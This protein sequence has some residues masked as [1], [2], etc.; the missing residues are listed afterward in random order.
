MKSNEEIKKVVKEKYSQIVNKSSSCCSGCGCSDGQLP[1]DIM[2][3]SYKNVEGYIKDADLSLG[4]GIPTEFANIK[5]GDTVLDLGSGAGNDVFV[6]RNIVGDE[7]FV[8]GVDMTQ[9]MIVKAEKNKAKT[10]YQ[11]VEFRLGEIENLPIEEN[12]VDVVI[13]NCVLNLVPDKEKA[14]KEIYRVLKSGKHF[15]VSD[16]VVI[17]ELPEKIKNSLELYAGCVAGASQKEEYL[18]IIEKTGFKKIEIKKEK[19]I[20]VDEKL[21]KLFL[22]EQDIINLNE[23]NFGIYSITVYGIK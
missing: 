10:G 21:I 23:N 8:I 14:F 15:C 11:N 16:I 17:G 20:E 6:A 19:K 12:S 22:N 18:A 2:A 3:D 9:D 1:I 4:C 5:K 7:G 13:S